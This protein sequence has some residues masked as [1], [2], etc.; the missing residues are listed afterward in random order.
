MSSL[1]N[2]YPCS[3]V[4][5]PDKALQAIFRAIVV[6]TNFVP[7]VRHRLGWR[8]LKNCSV[9]VEAWTAKIADWPGVFGMIWL[10][11]DITEQRLAGCFQL[12]YFPA[13]DEELVESYAL[14]A[15]ARTQQEDYLARVRHFAI[16]PD[17]CDLFY[18][19]DLILTLNRPEMDVGLTLQARS[20]LAV[21]AMDGLQLVA[22]GQPMN[23]VEP[24][25]M[26]QDLAAFRIARALFGVFAAS[27]AFCLE[28]PAVYFRHGVQPGCMT[29]CWS[30]GR[31]EE[32]LA[33]DIWTHE[34]QLD[35]G[36]TQSSRG[37]VDSGKDLIVWRQGDPVPS[38]WQAAPWWQAHRISNYKSL[39]KH[40]LGIDDR[41]ALIVLTG[42][43]G[44]GK[45]TFLEHFI[46]YQIQ[47][48]RFVAVIQNEIGATGLD[49]K[50]LGSTNIKVTEIDEGCICCTLTGQLKPALQQICTD[51]QP[52]FIVVETT[53]LANPMNFMDELVALTDMV[54]IDS[55]TTVV[56]G[57]LC[58]SSRDF[59]RVVEP[60]IQSADILLLNKVDKMSE[61]AIADT[62][63]YLRRI[64]THAPIIPCIR[65]DINPGLLYS[66]D[67]R[68]AQPPLR[69]ESHSKTN[70]HH[71]H[72]QD[73]IQSHKLVFNKALNRQK[74]MK[75]IETAR[76]RELFRIKGIVF[77]MDTADPMLV[78]Y[79]AGRYE[80][81]VFADRWDQEG[82]LI[83]IGQDI[84]AESIR[85]LF[86][87]CQNG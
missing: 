1:H 21:M 71:C 82:F 7:A 47:R 30:D 52:D 78:Q 50:L 28:T 55:V 66:L 87:R 59:S 53:G 48:D 75:T 3:I 76:P 39:D 60:Q 14:Q 54:R 46:A 43:L 73:R 29:C 27:T 12:N 18:I 42:F 32:R 22:Q 34:C 64:N 80:I 24:G 85:A 17:F 56:D 35:F 2:L 83:F 74:F 57:P 68:E 4:D 9:D 79:V 69:P 51:F 58:R 26:D 49:A 10:A 33:G 77:F 25:G 38:E 84:D 61:Q 81:S 70:H 19:G 44:S 63:A 23:L 37:L 11:S 36:A 65:G 72:L 8:G 86:E 13:P 62:Q 67:P 16:Y 45:T 20:R 5:E 40:L 41:P 15:A 6:R 31:R